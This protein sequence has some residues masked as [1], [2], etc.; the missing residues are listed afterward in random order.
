MS[1]FGQEFQA[2]FRWVDGHADVLGLLA[3]P[4]VLRR[5]TFALAEPFQDAGITKVA[6]VEARGFALGAPVALHLRAGFVPIRKGGGIHPG[7]K[8]RMATAPDWR[9]EV[10][11][12]EVQRSVLE[13]ED[14]VLIVDD[15]AE[16]GSQAWARSLIEGCG[17][18]YV[19]LSLLVD[20]LAEDMRERL[21]PVASVARHDE[22]PPSG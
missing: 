20:Q 6:G 17:S 16:T 7:E 14:R 13:P 10:N 8:L 21:V 22:L 11:Q 5:L 15:W 3:D 19:G 18:V 2:R 1:D 4:E 12:L 9:G